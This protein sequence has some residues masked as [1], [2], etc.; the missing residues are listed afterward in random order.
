MK[1]LSVVCVFAFFFADSVLGTEPK[2]DDSPK[3]ESVPLTESDIKELIQLDSFKFKLADCQD[4]DRVKIEFRCYEL[5]NS[6]PKILWSQEFSRSD[7]TSSGSNPK[8]KD[9]SVVTFRIDF[10][11]KTNGRSNALIS[12]DSELEISVSSKWLTPS[13]VLGS[14]DNPLTKLEPMEKTV[15][16]ASSYETQLRMAKED[17]S[18]QRLIYLAP[19]KGFVGKPVG[20]PKKWDELFPRAEVVLQ[21][22][23]TKK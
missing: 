9:A 7:F 1:I 17:H 2:K 4:G 18:V 10:K 14:F 15:Y 5:Q 11:S 22:L 13:T 23:P 8:Q 19:S 16:I 21:N 12:S 6:Q 20:V 3:A